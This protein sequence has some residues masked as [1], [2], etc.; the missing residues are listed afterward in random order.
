MFTGIIEA[1]GNVASL[2]SRGGDKCLRVN[3]GEL[4]LS[5]VKPGDSIAVS[6]VCLTAIQLD[7]NSFVADVSSETLVHTTLGKLTEGSRVNLEKALTPSSRLGGHMVSGHVDAVGEILARE[8][9]ARSIKF[10]IAVPKNLIKYI[11]R[12]GSI[13]VDGISLTVN[14]VDEKSFSLNVIPHTLNQTTMNDYAIGQP[15]NLE[16][17]IVARYLEQLLSGKSL[18]TSS[19]VTTDLLKRYGFF[20]H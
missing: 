20:D 17:D 3:T 16:V 15:V 2:E 5:D 13:C 7:P 8:K 6:G 14:A 4:D 12:K 9:D 19:G 10:Q 18:P 11:A 1:V